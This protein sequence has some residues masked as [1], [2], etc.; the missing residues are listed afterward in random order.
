[1]ISVKI[2]SET[3]QQ[4]CCKFGW[5]DLSNNTHYSEF[6]AMCGGYIGTILTE[7]LLTSLADFIHYYTS[8]AFERWTNITELKMLICRYAGY[9]FYSEV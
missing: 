9:A 6:L 5:C 2:T 7:E 8:N 1:M 3:M 4:T